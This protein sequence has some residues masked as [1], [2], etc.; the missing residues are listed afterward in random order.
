MSSAPPARALSV[1]PLAGEVAEPY[2]E[3][4]WP[5]LLE[6]LVDAKSAK[7]TLHWGRNY[8]YVATLDLGA[9][10][11]DVVV[12]QFRHDSLKPRLRRAMRGT[13]AER[14]WRSARAFL[15]AGLETPEPVLYADHAD[16]DGP[17]FYVCVHEPERLEA[18]Y[19]LRAMNAR[20]QERDFP[21]LDGARFV[22]ELG[23]MLA[24]MH[25]ADIWHRDMTSGNVLLE[26]SDFARTAQ[27]EP[28]A[29]ALSVIDLSRARIDRKLSLAER[30]RDLS[31]MPV[32]RR[33]DQL[34][35][36]EAYFEAAGLGG[37]PQ[38]LG[39]SLY[40]FF[41][42]SFLLKN[43]TKQRVRGGL[44]TVVDLVLPRRAAHTHIPDADPE[45]GRRDKIV[46]DPLSDQPHQH[47]SRWE[48]TLVRL[49][50]S[51]RHVT[52][53]VTLARSAPAIR[54]RYRALAA[55]QKAPVPWKGA[56][57][58]LRPYPEDPQALL[59]AVDE[60]GVRHTLLRLHPWQEEHEQEEALA[61]ALL[62]R[63]LEVSFALP[64]NRELVNDLARWHAQV[65][66]IAEI[67][68][69]LGRHFQIGQA[70]NRSK[71]G[72]WHPGEYVT[73]FRLASTVLR[74]V[75]RDVELLGPAVIDFEFHGLPALLESE[76]RW[77]EFDVL[78]SLL[79]VD[80]RGAPENSQ[81]GFDTVGKV[82][83]LKSMA[84]V[85]RNCPSGRVWI[86]E[87]N[88]PLR[89]GP[90]S[91]AGRDV[92]VSEDEQA[93]YLARYYLLVLTTGLVERV[94]WWQPI[95]KGY[96]LIDPAGGSLRRRPAFSAL[97]TLERTL[98]GLAFEERMPAMP[99]VHLLR[100][101]GERSVVVAWTAGA[102]APS[103]P[104]PEGTHT[105]RS[106]DGSESA[107]QDDVRLGPSPIFLLS[108]QGWE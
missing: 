107:A 31:R 37:A 97:A 25:G 21:D 63:G 57:I 9:V 106:L 105:F 4:D 14:S 17:A 30:M 54:A 108:G 1:G 87:V 10:Q 71:W 99:G 32:L 68:T 48:K 44:R 78:S 102:G 65:E 13:K 101:G 59:D 88:W 22:R 64:Q 36:L 39:A 3:L 67:F 95:A 40:R 100:F 103:I 18:R 76:D 86:T 77:L 75:R 91:P 94:F 85:G 41:H 33:E 11:R 55:E 8:L 70:I 53:L 74:E 81:M 60:L 66:R 90:H 43:T 49:R 5:V 52:T 82:R 58:A 92:A 24:R 45:A 79:Y 35:Y 61:R 84:E 38:R 7:E 46:W 34:P 96:G 93:D 20:T 47:A 83:L 15:D 72:I 2:A 62:D 6:D 50:D 89:E 19:L 42:R 12:K 56:G 28:S 80:R 69:P 29:A 73:L 23:R 51:P 104:A 16:K 26:R 27:T 98:A